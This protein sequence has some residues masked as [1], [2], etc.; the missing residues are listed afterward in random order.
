MNKY[1]EIAYQ[2]AKKTKTDIP[3]GCVLINKDGMILSKSSNQVEKNQN[4][5]FRM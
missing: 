5:I 1:M 4:S 3:I 2:I